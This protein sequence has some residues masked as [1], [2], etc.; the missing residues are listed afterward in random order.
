MKRIYKVIIAIVL[1]LLVGFAAERILA[2]TNNNNNNNNG[3]VAVSS[4]DNKTEVKE[5]TKKAV[6]GQTSQ[7]SK[8][9]VSNTTEAQTIVSP[10]ITE[11]RV[12]ASNDITSVTNNGNV[13]EDTNVDNTDVSNDG[14]LSNNNLTNDNV[15]N[16]NVNGDNAGNNNS[17]V[18]TPKT[19]SE[20]Y[21]SIVKPEAFNGSSVN[22]ILNLEPLDAN[23]QSNYLPSEQNAADASTLSALINNPYQIVVKEG[24][25]YTDYLDDFVSRFIGSFESQDLLTKSSIDDINELAVISDVY[26]IETLNCNVVAGNSNEFAIQ[27]AFRTFE[28]NIRV[29]NGAN[30]IFKN[31]WGNI[32]GEYLYCDWTFLVKRVSDSIYQIEGISQ[33]NDVISAFTAKYPDNNYMKQLKVIDVDSTKDCLYEIYKDQLYVSYDKGGQWKQVPITIEELL[34][35]GDGLIP[36]LIKYKNDPYN[37]YLDEESY[38]I[39]PEK[40]VFVYGGNSEIPLSIIISTD[41]GNTWTRTVVS[42]SMVGAR[43]TFISFSEDGNCGYLVVGAYR[44]MHA[45]LTFIYKTTDGG[46]SWSFVSSPDLGGGYHTLTVSA[47]FS[48]DSIGFIT[49]GGSQDQ[50]VWYTMDGGM[51]WQNFIFGEKPESEYSVSMAYIK[52]FVGNKGVI[53]VGTYDLEKPYYYKYVSEDYGKTWRLVGLVNTVQFLSELQQY[54]I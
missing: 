11:N 42:N 47:T 36:K 24:D 29:Y 6:G 31:G 40:T 38:Y 39:T 21:A 4:S 1:L 28:N 27:C 7:D 50:S 37:F 30:V 3:Q 12:I 9:S 10:V 25:P 45:E 5:E 41:G 8:T 23:N 14:N 22:S 46:K 19:I 48:T 18:I 53:Y 54:E 16:D 20:I 43:R 15:N 32:K 52:P 2:K 35:H 26:K 34:G 13:Q 51:T 17:T 44:T 49:M 33:T